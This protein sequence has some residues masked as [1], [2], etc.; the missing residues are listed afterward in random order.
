[1]WNPSNL[2]TAPSIVDSIKTSIG[3]D[4]EGVFVFNAFITGSTLQLRAT[5]NFGA[6]M[7]VLLNFKAFYAF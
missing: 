7:T 1:V 2:A 5:N 3:G 4:T 6:N